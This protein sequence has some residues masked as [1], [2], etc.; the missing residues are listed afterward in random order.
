MYYIYIYWNF[1]QIVFRQIFTYS[2]QTYFKECKRKRIVPYFLL[3]CLPFYDPLS[4]AVLLLLHFWSSKFPS[5]SS[6]RRMS[7]SNSLRVGGL[8]AMG[9]LSF[10]SPETDFLI[11]PSFLKG[12]FAIYGI[13]SWQFFS[14]SILNMLPTSFLFSWLVL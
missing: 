5:V 7:F 13:L 8:L 10:L 12:I 9:S 3:T 6:I 14:F 2:F 1:H 11:S 4:P